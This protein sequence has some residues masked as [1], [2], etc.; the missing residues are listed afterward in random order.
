MSSSPL[1]SRSWHE[2]TRP[3]RPTMA[4]DLICAPMTASA[5]RPQF[6][7]ISGGAEAAKFDAKD[8][9]QAAA[10]TGT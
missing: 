8:P 1:K 7:A 3:L 10:T 9:E 6:R 2:V 4:P 5:D